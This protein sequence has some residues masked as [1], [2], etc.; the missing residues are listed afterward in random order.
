MTSSNSKSSPPFHLEQVRE[1]LIK[2]NQLFEE[3]NRAEVGGRHD[4]RGMGADDESIVVVSVS[5]IVARYDFDLN[6]MWPNPVEP[7][8]NGVRLRAVTISHHQEKKRIAVAGDDGVIY[9]IDD[10]C[11]VTKLP[12]TRTCIASLDTVVI[13]DELFYV[14]CSDDL[15][16]FVMIDCQGKETTI[17]PQYTR[18]RYACVYA[19]RSIYA[20]TM[21]G[22]LL[23]VDPETRR[24]V[25]TINSNPDLG[26]L[27][28]ICVADIDRNG[29]LEFIVRT[30]KYPAAV[31]SINGAVKG[32]LPK[33]ID[34]IYPFSPITN[35]TN[36]GLDIVCGCRNGRLYL[37]E[38]GNESANPVPLHYELDSRI[39]GVQ[40]IQQDG[41]EYIIAGTISG[42]LHKLRKFEI[43]AIDNK[44]Q[45]FDGEV[46]RTFDSTMEYLRALL[47]SDDKNL[48]SHAIDILWNYDKGSEVNLRSPLVKEFLVNTE[49]FCQARVPDLFQR[50]STK[51]PKQIIDVVNYLEP[52]I[53][54]DLGGI[55]CDQLRSLDDKFQSTNPQ[56]V[57]SLLV[58]RSQYHQRLLDAASTFSLLGQLEKYL[59]EANPSADETKL[60]IEKLQRLKIQGYD[61]AWS[62]TLDYV[63]WIR[64]QGGNLI[65]NVM[66]SGLLRIN[67]KDGTEN[68]NLR[69]TLPQEV[70]TRHSAVYTD[71]GADVLIVGTNTGWVYFFNNVGILE[72][73]I[74]LGTGNI[75][76]LAKTENHLIVGWLGTGVKVYPMIDGEPEETP[77]AFTKKPTCGHP[78]CIITNINHQTV[79]FI[80]LTNHGHLTGYAITEDKLVEQVWTKNV[81]RD[82]GMGVA[83]VILVNNDLF[84][85]TS[86]GKIYCMPLNDHTI[87]NKIGDFGTEPFLISRYSDSQNW[88]LVLGTRDG[89]IQR[90]NADGHT[91]TIIPKLDHSVS[92]GVF[93]EQEDIQ[94]IITIEGSQLRAYRTVGAEILENLE[95]K[96]NKFTEGILHHEY[97]C[98]M[99]TPFEPIPSVQAALNRDTVKNDI[100]EVIL[101]K[102]GKGKFIQVNSPMGAGVSAILVEVTKSLVQQKVVA[103]HVDLRKALSVKKASELLPW[104]LNEI[105][106]LLPGNISGNRGD[107][108]QRLK[109][110]YFKTFVETAN[111]MQ[112]KSGW[113]GLVM[114]FDNWE[115]LTDPLRKKFD[116]SLMSDI[117]A[118][119]ESSPLVSVIFSSYRPLANRRNRGVLINVKYLSHA[120]IFEFLDFLNLAG[121]FVDESLKRNMERYSGGGFL[122]LQVLCHEAVKIAQ[123]NGNLVG[124]EPKGSPPPNRTERTC[125]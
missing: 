17:A 36:D 124:S 110:T 37:F 43:Q 94:W 112:K 101:K 61:I 40:T 15:P 48:K 11:L 74:Q 125:R 76:C 67:L 23:E 115:Y 87:C 98:N 118:A 52:P 45:D 41:I 10:N 54:P 24:I 65:A 4:I 119:A 104:L 39:W 14:V 77:L 97:D 38:T 18:V 92:N 122:I 72:K 102:T 35:E 62:I 107:Q 93:F 117:Y 69:I 19:N 51:A 71:E 21:E 88:W 123:R 26:S 85:I 81:V 16:G 22:D 114:I 2:K 9:I 113:N 34:T 12:T 70:S 49:T 33:E 13:K 75:E 28:R 79:Q 95:D 29:E 58:A 73:E 56:L 105:N 7:S 84:L 109:S 1:L 3:V 59:G 55:I 121:V 53:N 83:E 63:W 27:C 99:Y 5:G 66:G 42:K 20:V 82:V 57:P 111:A 100:L 106:S 44:I 120:E 8:G 47:E 68:S 91:G 90:I 50:L 64:E 116:Q 78:T 103:A 80:C 32:Q 60:A 31:L 86:T 30:A 108:H 89:K 46:T 6:P 96:I 25:R